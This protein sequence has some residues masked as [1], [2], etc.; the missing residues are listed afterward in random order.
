MESPKGKALIIDSTFADGWALRFTSLL[1][2][3]MKAAVLNAFGEQLAVETLPDLV[4]GTGEVVV[5]VFAAGVASYTAGI[6]SG[7]RNYL[8]EPPVVPGPGG[9]G[10]VRTVGPD[11]TKLSVGD[12]VFCDLTIR[13]RDDASRPDMILL[14]WTGV[15]AAAPS[16]WRFPKT[17]V[18]LSM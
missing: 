6:F 5:D 11:A 2:I 1:D 9:I 15:G 10:R 7:A 4:R 17:Q 3:S 13:S 12:W 18:S 8:L 16:K 14:G